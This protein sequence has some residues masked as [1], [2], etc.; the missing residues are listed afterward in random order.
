MLRRM[1]IMLGVVAVIVA[2]LA[3]SKY[4]SITRQ[5]AMFSAPR[6]RRSA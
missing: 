1:L 5:I 2:V 3:G 4:L 6:T